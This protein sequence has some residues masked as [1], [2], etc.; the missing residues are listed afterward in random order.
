M[1][2]K[3]LTQQ[4]AA[5]ALAAIETVRR[6]RWEADYKRQAKGLPA[7]LLAS[8]LAPTLAF[9]WSKGGAHA[10]LAAHISSWILR[11]VFGK[12]G[13]GSVERCL[14]AL[15]EADSAGYRRAE[16]E[17]LEIAGWLKRLADAY[18]EG[19]ES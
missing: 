12:D 5:A 4:R 6:Q 19:G 10:E 15:A 14:R 1:A 16:G 11:S 2:V 13:D 8:G 9:L 17:A 7:M 3:T 18:L